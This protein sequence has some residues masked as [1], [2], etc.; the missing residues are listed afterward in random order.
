M[1]FKRLPS[2]QVHPNSG[3]G[4]PHIISANIRKIVCVTEVKL[5]NLLLI[6]GKKKNPLSEDKFTFC[7]LQIAEFIK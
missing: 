4:T 3:K 6:G 5:Q 1:Y 2:Q 7:V